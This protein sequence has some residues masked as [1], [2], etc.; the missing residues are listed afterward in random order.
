MD[1]ASFSRVYELKTL[2]TDKVLADIN[3]VIAR[4]EQLG[5]AKNRVASDG[6]A[7]N[8][9]EFNASMQTLV[10]NMESIV[11]ATN[12][13][14]AANEKLAT[15]I[16]QVTMNMQ[17]SAEAMGENLTA[18]SVGLTKVQGGFQEAT[19][20]Q[21][22]L[23]QD[24]LT[25]GE[26]L[27]VLKDQIS[28]TTNDLKYL[29]EE[30]AAGR[31]SEDEYTAATGRLNV[32]LIEQ[33]AQAQALTE[34]LKMQAVAQDAAAGSINEARTQAALYRKELNG[35][36]LS[37]EEGVARQKELIATIA[38][39]DLFIKENADL[40]TRQKINI[41]NYPTVGA[42]LSAIRAEMQ[43]LVVAGEANSEEFAKL[44]ARAQELSAS[45]RMV[46]NDTGK[47]VFSVENMEKR[48]TSMG[49]RMLIHLAIFQAAI[50]IYEVLKDAY[51]KNSK[52]LDDYN[53][54]LKEVDKT[55][56]S[57]LVSEESHTRELIAIATHAGT[58]MKIRQQAVK[59]LQDSY[60]DYFGNLT[61][62]EILTGKIADATERLNNALYAKVNMQANESKAQKA[63]DRKTAL[64]DELKLLEKEHEGLRKS[65]E[66]NKNNKELQDAIRKN[67]YGPQATEF[68][69]SRFSLSATDEKI[70]EVARMVL[71]ADAEVNAYL[72]KADA[73]AVDA[74]GVIQKKGKEKTGK[75]HDYTNALLEAQKKLTDNIAK[76]S[77]LRLQIEMQEQK[78][79]F[80]SVENGLNDRLK[81]YAIYASDEKKLLKLQSD[82]AIKDVQDWLDKIADIEKKPK[83]KRTVEENTLLINK[84][85]LSKQVDDLREEYTLKLGQVAAT[86][87]SDIAGITKSS[88]ETE[89]KTI[90]TELN[91][92]LTDITNKYTD[93]ILD[94]YHNKKDRSKQDKEIGKLDQGQ[95]V[96]QDEA[97]LKSD[98]A[99]IN[100]TEVA[101]QKAHN[102]H[103]VDLEKDLRRRLVELYK[104][105]AEDKKKKQADLNKSDKSAEEVKKQISDEAIKVAET[106]A[107]QYM[108]LLAKEDAAKQAMADRSLEWNKRVM[109]TE[110]QSKNEQLT[111]ERAYALAQQQ[112]HKEQMQQE[113][114][115]AEAQLIVSYVI[116]LA[117]DWEMGW[118]A[119]AIAAAGQTVGLALS[120]AALSRAPAYADGIYGNSSHPGGPAWV[121]DGGE[122]E[123][124][125]VGNKYSLSPSTATLTNLPA[126]AQVVPMSHIFSSNM[127]ANLKA[128]NFTSTSSSS[129]GGV[130]HSAS[131]QAIHSSLTTIASGMANMQVSLDTH[132]LSSRQNTNYYKQVKL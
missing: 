20:A 72:K 132:K 101:I 130:D 11:A 131:F 74:A 32:E 29:K 78:L 77:E 37:T 46:A 66:L 91:K 122:P 103:M 126:G 120:E 129:V 22:Q 49:F 6:G 108:A 117:K 4:L 98:A 1:S 96:E 10:K 79:I 42:E 107:N 61:K 16:E 50:E 75:D 5:Q 113:R 30:F 123:L 73:Y 33:R 39:L 81:A 71:E 65:Y 112:L 25:M 7:S 17:K 110:V 119:G 35:L 45:M 54:S 47:A 68:G 127:G 63:A 48:V 36:N 3:S 114:K 111:N 128:P 58:A 13:S 69:L 95:S 97:K 76:E 106:V 89:F 80:D 23:M 31:M 59:E 34:M 90:D 60:P 125:R 104:Q 100:D 41:G 62:E 24:T 94:V 92:Q 28:A 57:T 109:D 105:E 55:L 43:K 67:P 87:N 82:A 121:G 93:A 56:Q 88:L 12:K 44:S 85:Q 26:Q 8:M 124:M 118:P 52:A 9:N 86:I 70:K 51:T 38:E 14:A 15:S 84:A 83:D 102:D 99:K 18:T 64:E 115:R 53:N 21:A 27:V 2:G 40:Y 19:E 116:G